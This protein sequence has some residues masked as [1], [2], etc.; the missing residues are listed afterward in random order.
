MKKTLVMAIGVILLVILL[1]LVIVD[2]HR[3]APA[4]VD[5]APAGDDEPYRQ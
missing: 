1:R 3:V 4:S 2:A 5:F